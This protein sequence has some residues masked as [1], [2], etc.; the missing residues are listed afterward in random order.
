MEHL[1]P[2]VGVGVII[3]HEGFCL[4]GKRHG[5]RGAGTWALPGGHLSLGVSVEE[6]AAREVMEKTGLVIDLLSK[7]LLVFATDTQPAMKLA[8]AVS[9]AVGLPPLYPPRD[10]EG[11]IVFDAGITTNA[12]SSRSSRRKRR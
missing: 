7:R 5:S 12:R 8:D 1:A 3:M 10:A 4:L 2:Q 6:C 11:R 9:I